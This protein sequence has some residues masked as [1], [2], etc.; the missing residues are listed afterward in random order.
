[1]HIFMKKFNYIYVEKTSVAQNVDKSIST[2][3]VQHLHKFFQIKLGKSATHKSKT[4]KT[5]K[6]TKGKNRTYKHK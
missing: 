6:K 1:M 2:K 3:I 4:L 5:K